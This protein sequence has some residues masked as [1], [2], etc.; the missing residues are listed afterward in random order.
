MNPMRMAMAGA[1]L[2]LASTLGATPASATTFSGRLDDPGNA[3]LV[4]SDLGTP[5]FSDQ[6]AIANNLALYGFTV[7]TAGLVSIV[8]TGFVA[9]GV[10][11]YFS[12]FTGAGASAAFLDSNY[13]Q[14]FST[15]GDFSY[16]AVLDAGSYQ[17]ALGTFA[18]MSFAENLGTGTLADGFIGLG[19]PGAAA[20]R[21]PH[22]RAAPSRPPRSAFSTGRSARRARSPA[23][24]R[25][26][27]ARPGPAAA[28]TPAPRQG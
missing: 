6:F 9:G 4:G 20:G 14:A 19:Q 26:R 27:A 8:S 5:D 12:L 3:A 18:N 21:A 10:D 1:V 13:L 2:A 11:P 15:G 17:I 28:T 22:T 16:A 25:R 7:G 23:R 24:A